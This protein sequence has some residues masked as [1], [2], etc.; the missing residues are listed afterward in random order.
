M[1]ENLLSKGQKDYSHENVVHTASYYLFGH[2]TR[3]DLKA[4]STKAQATVLEGKEMTLYKRF[5]ANNYEEFLSIIKQ[6]FSAETA[7]DRE[8]LASF[9]PEQLEKDF[10][11]VVAGYLNQ[12]ID[13]EVEIVFK[14]DKSDKKIARALKTLE[15]KNISVKTKGDL[16]FFTIAFT[17]DQ[18][19]IIKQMINQTYSNQL[20]YNNPKLTRALRK[21]LAD[22]MR[23]GE[24][25]IISDGSKPTLEK[26]QQEF[27]IDNYPWGYTA[28]EIKEA[29]QDTKSAEYQAF[30]KAKS[31]IHD[32]I[33]NK[34]ARGST[35]LQQ[36]AE[37]VYNKKIGKDADIRFFTGAGGGK[38]SMLKAVKGSLGE[39]Q[40]ALIFDYFNRKLK[41]AGSIATIVGN[42]PAKGGEQG[43]A[44]LS[45]SLDSI[46]G[47]QV[48]NWN[49]FMQHN[50]ETNIHPIEFAKTMND[51]DDF[52][53]FVAN[54]YFNTTYMAGRTEYFKTMK[55][56]LEQRI[57]ELQNLDIVEGLSDKVSF[58]LIEGK[59]L[60]PASQLLTLMLDE[61]GLLPPESIWITSS[62][63]GKSDWEYR[64]M[65][66]NNENKWWNR[67]IDGTWDPTT[68]NEKT[69]N[70]LV[71]KT[72]SI[73][74][75]MDLSG[76]L[77]RFNILG[78]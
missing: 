45:L 52:L 74:T 23:S 8:V 54:I 78:A 30:V 9:S 75:K 41:G 18:A 38:S 6:L 66:A 65:T 14:Y 77:A 59:Y 72:I 5:G 47:V 71:S 1:A 64:Q 67:N 55:K 39:F 73:R 37:E 70:N 40:A 12:A 25:N 36:V 24:L 33:M 48:K 19:G 60:V 61:D 3:F 43:K 35:I 17:D 28:S 10:D 49:E 4:H 69:F 51:G 46:V 31:M 15:G 56:D 68:E 44:D 42:L 7:Q 34:C 16:G 50:I 26:V 21:A 20:H 58:Y 32:F 22:K 62:Y 29:L 53:Q 76:K 2:N 27:L 11:T 57:R 13:K 63:K